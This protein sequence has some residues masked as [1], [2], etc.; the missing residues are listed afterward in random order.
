[1]APEIQTYRCLPGKGRKQFGLLSGEQYRLWLGED[2]ML[3]VRTTGYSERFR[4]FYFKD[5]EAFVVCKTKGAAVATVILAIVAAIAALA[6]FWI[7]QGLELSLM[8]CLILGAVVTALPST[9]LFR[10]AWLGPTCVC[11]LHTAVQVEDLVALRRLRRA[12]Q[13]I[14]ILKPLIEAAQGRLTPEEL[15]AHSEAQTE[16]R[17]SPHAVPLLTRQAGPKPHRRHEEGR[18]HAALF[19]MLLVLALL[20]CGDLFYPSLVKDFVDS[21]CIGAT[22]V[23]AIIALRRQRH[24]DLPQGL[25]N[26]TWAAIGALAANFS[27]GLAIG[28]AIG[29]TLPFTDP[30]F[31]EE[32]PALPRVHGNP[33]LLTW[34]ALVSV[35]YSVVAVLGLMRLRAFRAAY[36]AARAQATRENG[37]D[38]KGSA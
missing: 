15:E 21:A 1:M 27:V 18:V 9:L 25:T 12:E 26:L 23:I 34:C 37:A 30:S 14:G 6:G 3:H 17:A 32:F 4:R 13:T 31:Y 20:A 16:V 7:G 11:W 33:V 24:S 5:I 19:L 10:N 28:F 8:S 29:L 22:V 38:Q 2:H 35:L 36:A